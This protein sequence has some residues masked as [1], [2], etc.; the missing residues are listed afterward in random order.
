MGFVVAVYQDRMIGIVI[1]RPEMHVLGGKHCQH[2]EAQGRN[3][4]RQ[5][6]TFTA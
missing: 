6:A 3:R 2:G 1:R 5:S 4:R